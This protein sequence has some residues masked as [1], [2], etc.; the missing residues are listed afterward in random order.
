MN[1]KEST[2]SRTASD[3]KPINKKKWLALTAVGAALLLIPRRS[4]RQ[5]SHLAI[6]NTNNISNNKANN[7]N[8]DE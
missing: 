6:D 8:P 3:S 7:K 2:T 5:N 1:N 4:S